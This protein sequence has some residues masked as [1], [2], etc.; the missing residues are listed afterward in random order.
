M[1]DWEILRRQI[2]I[3][4]QITAVADN[5]PISQA[6]VQITAAP[7]AFMN[8]VR[9]YAKL[10]GNAWDGLTKR[11]DRTETA[12]DG[13]YYFLDLPNGD[14]TI[15]AYV[16]H[17]LP[18]YDYAEGEGVVSRD[19]TDTVQ[20]A[21]VD[22]ALPP[23][24][25]K[26]FPP[27]FTPQMIADCQLWLQADGLALAD[28]AT[29]TSWADSSGQAVSVTT[30]N[31]PTYLAA[32]FNGRSALRFDG[33]TTYFTL[34]L[35][36]EASE[37]TIFA[38]YDITPTEGSSSYLFEAQ[39]GRLT[40]DCAQSSTPHNLR[41]NDGSWRTIAPAIAGK[42]VVTWLFSGTTGELTRNGVSLGSATYTPQS[43][44]GVV[45]LGANYQGRSSFFKGDVAE[46][47][48]YSR[49]LSLDERQTVENYLNGRYALFS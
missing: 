46:F 39:T 11:V 19:D 42:Q 12:A 43:I 20:A 31:G 22:V 44:G 13:A 4:G 48:Y 30:E 36:N 16:P 21:T 41:W 17:R 8:K 9:L 32:G 49:A 28:G 25:G 6:Q 2:A 40:L 26:T 33:A 10:H 18:L 27:A 45:T 5:A 35:A 34:D 3:S 23:F 14:Y 38:V 1:S 29:V 37:H 7:D 24:S 47:L 15:S